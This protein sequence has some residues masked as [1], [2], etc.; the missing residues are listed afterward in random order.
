MHWQ[1]NPY[2][3]PLLIAAVVSIWLILSAWQRRSMPGAIPFGLLML[4]AAEW[5]L[6]YALELVSPDLPTKVF[7][8]N[9]IWPGALIASA[10]WLAFALQYTGRG[11]WLTWR[12]VALLSILPLVTVL[13]AWTNNIHGLI[14]S[15]I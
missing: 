8:D 6:S 2:V 3:I 15:N 5:S 1:F 10:A 11:K 4:G 13:L 14:Y 12:T 7:W 9:F